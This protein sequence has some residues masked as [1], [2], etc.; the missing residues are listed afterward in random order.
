MSVMTSMKSNHVKNV[1]L[2]IGAVLAAA[3]V[4]A[5]LVYAIYP[6]WPYRRIY[7]RVAGLLAAVAVVRFVRRKHHGDW[8]VIGF[9]ARDSWLFAVGLGIAAGI[10]SG[11][12]LGLL[13]TLGGAAVWKVPGVGELAIELAK[14]MAVGLLVGFLEELFFRGFIT[15]ELSRGLGRA[16]A[17]VWSS[18]F[19]ASVHFIRPLPPLP[20]FLTEFVGLFI[21]GC[22]L[23]WLFLR[24]GA[25]YLAIGLHAGWVFFMKFGRTV[26]EYR[27]ADPVWFWGGDRLPAAVSAWILFPI[28]GWLVF[29]IY[30]RMR[31]NEAD[32][33]FK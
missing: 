23:A 15:G 27:P 16:K 2:T 8:S 24:T 7:S 12:F 22:V 20:D 33:P 5:G 4:L 10:A 29:R 31:P 3:A 1:V 21:V 13:K 14:S 26:L 28:T 32:C 9:P 18:L 30:T 17:I 6:A 19:F 25:V 11:F